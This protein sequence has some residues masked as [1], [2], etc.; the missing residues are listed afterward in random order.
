VIRDE[1]KYWVSNRQRPMLW[2]ELER[3]ATMALP[4][5]FESVG[6]AAHDAVIVLLCQLLDDPRRQCKALGLRAAICAGLSPH[7]IF[8]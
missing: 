7:R 5:T 3:N 4:V 1:E 8:D 2:P 6:A